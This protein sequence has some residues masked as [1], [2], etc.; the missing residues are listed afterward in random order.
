MSWTRDQ[1]IEREA[2]VLVNGHDIEFQALWLKQAIWARDLFQRQGAPCWKRAQL[3]IE[4]G[5]KLLDAEEIW[6]DR[7]T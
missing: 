5:E 6:G 7:P 4:D 3:P 2:V 1:K